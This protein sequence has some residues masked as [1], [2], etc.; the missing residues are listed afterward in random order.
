M[1]RVFTCTTLKEGHLVKAYSPRLL[2][3]VHF[4]VPKEEG[5]KRVFEILANLLHQK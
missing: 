5:L 2:K 3:E 4:F 1:I